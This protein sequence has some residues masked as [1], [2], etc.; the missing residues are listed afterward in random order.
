MPT[1]QPYFLPPPGNASLL[2]S[3][4][5]VLVNQEVYRIGLDSLEMTEEY[6][7]NGNRVFRKLG[8]GASRVTRQTNCRETCQIGAFRGEKQSKTEA[9][10][11]DQSNCHINCHTYIGAFGV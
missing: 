1:W 5:D 4:V 6:T 8:K 3:P 9:E 2:S 10:Q 11:C 7:V